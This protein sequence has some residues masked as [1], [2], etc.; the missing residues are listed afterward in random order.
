[1]DY[2][3]SQISGKGVPVQHKNRYD[4]NYLNNMFDSETLDM[5]KKVHFT[6]ITTYCTEQTLKNAI[7][8]H[9][10]NEGMLYLSSRIIFDKELSDGMVSNEKILRTNKKY[11]FEDIQIK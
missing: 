5:I 11:D 3:I 2:D 10:I 8:T 6:N 4:S 1:M 9:N 7:K